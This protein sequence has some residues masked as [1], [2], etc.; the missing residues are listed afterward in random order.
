GAIAS[1]VASGQQITVQQPTFGISIDAEGVLSTREFP[2]PTGRLFAQRV[3]S[4]KAGMVGGILRWSD[5][6]KVSLVKLERALASRSEAGEKPDDAMR[7]LAGL[8]RAQYAFFYPEQ[9]DIVIAGPAEGW[10]D[11]LS[12]RAIGLTTGR[13]TLLLEDLLVAL[14]AYPPGSRVKP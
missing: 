3:A 9:R 7:H 5:L 6:R 12:G 2:D 10:V 8:Q 4:A 13:P 14:R 1:Q 11:D